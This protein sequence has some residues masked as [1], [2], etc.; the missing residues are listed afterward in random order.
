MRA[1]G[2]VVPVTTKGIDAPDPL[3]RNR[4]SKNVEHAFLLSKKVHKLCSLLSELCLILDPLSD[5]LLL[6]LSQRF[7]FNQP[8]AV[9][10]V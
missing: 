10:R 2:K 4:L 5:Q 6:P 7:Y 3:N 9:L 1:R 8:I